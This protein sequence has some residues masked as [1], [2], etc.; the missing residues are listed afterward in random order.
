M[1]FGGTLLNV[2]TVLVGSTIG[3]LIGNRIPEKV[4]KGVFQVLGLFTLVLGVS[5]AI[6]GEAIL[7][8]IF[9]L[10]LGT[11]IGE[12]LDLDKKVEG[13]S[14]WLKTRLKL[15]NPKITEGM[16]TA[17]LLY[18]VGSMTI[19]GAIDEGMGNGSE[20]LM[21]KALMD[22]FS[23]I[24]LASVFGMGVGL[25]VVPML[26]FQGG[27][28]LLAFILGDFIAPVIINELS[29]V[30]G[31]LLVGLGINILEIK[32]IRIM[33]MLPSLLVVVLM[34]WLALYFNVI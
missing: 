6:K 18:C 21:T 14:D 8:I 13:L 30:G 15:K 17:F 27:I 9:S 10:I 3:I 4:T 33:N 16:L 11:V 28:T 25:S 32:H 24:A 29:A 1:L 26:L 19:L 23:S 5:M 12:L 22:G 20:I 7:I 2:L 31:V 34:A